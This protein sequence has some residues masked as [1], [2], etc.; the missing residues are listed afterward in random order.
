MGRDSP[1]IVWFLPTIP[2]SLLIRIYGVAVGLR[3]VSFGLA[4][5]EPDSF[6]AS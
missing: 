1:G 4:L 5:E 6:S 2:A 3:G